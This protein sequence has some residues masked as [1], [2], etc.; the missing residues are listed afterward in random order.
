MRATLFLALAA[1]AVAALPSASAHGAPTPVDFMA[2][3]LA[4][5][6]DDCGAHGDP[7]PAGSCRGSD[8]LIALDVQEKANGEATTL[9]FRFWLDKGTTFPVTNTLTFQ[10]GGAAKSFAIKTTN[11]QSYT[12]ESGFDAVAA[13][14]S[15]NDGTRSTVDASV[16]AAKVGAIGTKLTSIKVESKS[17]SN[18]GDYMP[19]GCRNNLGECS[20][21]D[22]ET[23][24]STDYTLRGPAYYAK[25]DAPTTP[26]RVPAGG[27]S[28]LTQITLTNSLSKSAQTLTL[29]LTGANGVSG[30]FH[31]GEPTSASQ[32]TSTKQVALQGKQQ[33]V[34]HLRLHGDTIDAAGTLTLTLTTD[35][36]GRVVAQIPYEVVPS[37]S[38]TDL[39]TTASS[40]ATSSKGS[41]AA[42]APLVALGLLAIALRRRS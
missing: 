16:D 32:Y 19:G 11:G 5:D 21:T 6:N 27:D 13:P 42:A 36:G 23:R 33:T 22:Q 20:G 28:Q 29:T 31:A 39:P 14:K 7:N 41:P 4:D 9:V 15:V 12:V 38:A 25:M 10:A 37:G 26:I 3:L 1:L 40:P 8:D 17:G 18:L 35:L 34:L 2:R 30:G 24:Y